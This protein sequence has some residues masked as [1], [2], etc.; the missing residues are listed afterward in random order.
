M[1][2]R[3]LINQTFRPLTTEDTAGTAIAKM[4][5]WHTHTLPVLD[6]QTRRIIGLISFETICNLPDE[7]VPLSALPLSP[8]VFAFGHQH[9]F[10]VAR[11][12]LHHELRFLAICDSDGIYEGVVRK[13]DL[14]DA[15]SELL[16]IGTTGSVITI[17]MAEQDFALSE[18]VQLIEQEG[19]KILGLTVSGSRHAQ[20]PEALQEFADLHEQDDQDQYQGLD[21]DSRLVQVSVKLN[22]NDTTALVAKLRRYGYNTLSENRYDMAD[23]DL[24][25]RADE[26]MHYLDL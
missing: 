24:S 4:D 16:N 2:A 14:I 6:T 5:A 15:F 17:G 25:S 22:L 18:L 9:I 19:A 10:E 26:L 8:A 23:L 3:K 7:S 12:M 20:K 21:Q 13:N 1:H 11:L